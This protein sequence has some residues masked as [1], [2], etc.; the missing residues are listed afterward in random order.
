MTYCDA[1][2]LFCTF[3]RPE[4]VAGQTLLDRNRG[5]GE[6]AKP[7]EAIY[8]GDPNTAFAILKESTDE[9]A[10]ETVRSREHIGPPFMHMQ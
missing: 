2:S 4:T 8:R 9:V 10:G 7:V 5:D 1:V 3:A 6:L